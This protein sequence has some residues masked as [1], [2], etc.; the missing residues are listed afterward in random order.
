MSNLYWNPEQPPPSTL[1]R[2]IVPCGSCLRISPIR[3][4]ARSETVTFSVSVLIRSIPEL[5]PEPDAIATH[6]VR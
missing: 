2:S 6:P 3:R 1:T 4:A 5:F